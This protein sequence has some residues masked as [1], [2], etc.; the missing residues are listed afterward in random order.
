MYEIQAAALHHSS[1]ITDDNT[2]GA[3][4]ISSF[5]GQGKLYL[6]S[7][8]TEAADNTS[9]VKIT[10]SDTEGGVY[11]DAGVAFAQVTNAGV[12][13]QTIDLN[14]DRFKR[15][16]KVVNDLGGTTPAVTYSVTLVAKKQST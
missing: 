16:V 8:A 6:S 3:T 13:F 12:S 5:H 2:S 15:W 7:S 11:T 10:H 1:R 9:D 4:D 14:V